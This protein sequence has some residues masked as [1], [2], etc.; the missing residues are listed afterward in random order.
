MEGANATILTCI[1]NLTAE[2][3]AV[4][5]PYNLRATYPNKAHMN[6]QL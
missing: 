1:H 4:Q 6:P 3:A 5:E 2:T